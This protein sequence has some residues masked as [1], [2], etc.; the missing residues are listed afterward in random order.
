MITS[1][2]KEDAKVFS[3]D[4]RKPHEKAVERIED[5]LKVTSQRMD[6]QRLKAN[7]LSAVSFF[8][9]YRLVAASWTGHVVAR[10]P[11]VPLRILESLTRRG[12]SNPRAHDCAFSLV[13]TLCTIGVK[14]NIPRALGFV[15]PK[16][17]FDAARMATRQQRKEKDN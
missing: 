15:P 13:Y 12:L 16:S 9:L 14:A 10:L 3:V 17:A 7:I 1:V 5:D 2:A 8:F 6:A 11:F 4:K